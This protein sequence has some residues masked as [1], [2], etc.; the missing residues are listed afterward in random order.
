MMLIIAT[1]CSACADPEP[2]VYPP[3]PL[4]EVLASLPRQ[5][6]VI[7]RNDPVLDRGEVYLWSL[8]GRGVPDS[9]SGV[10][11]YRGD[12]IGL[13]KPCET[14]QLNDSYWDPYKPEY[15]VKIE[16]ND[17]VGWMPFSLITITAE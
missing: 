1:A 11:G 16:Y 5:A 2:T 9:D 8:P 13:V 17:L 10:S 12:D 7:C 15:R 3:E 14:I 6:L 4:P